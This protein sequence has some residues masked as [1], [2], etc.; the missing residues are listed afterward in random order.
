MIIFLN[1]CINSGKTTT[2]KYIKDLDCGFTHI[3]GDDLREFTR[4]MPIEKSINLTLKNAIDITINFDQAS[5]HSV[6]SYPINDENY[7][8]ACALLKD[9]QIKH[10]AVTL[11]SGLDVLKT[12]RGNRALSNWVLNRIDELNQQGFVQPSFGHSRQFKY[13]H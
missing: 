1:G 2:A 11:F 9:T 10:V 12:N 6:I 13:E 7:G 8:F 4:R 3:K 5:I